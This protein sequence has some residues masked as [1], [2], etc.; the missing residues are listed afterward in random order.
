MF[1]GRREDDDFA[2]RI[3]LHG[4]LMAS[5]RR[6]AEELVKHPLDVFVRM[7]VA[8]PQDHVIARDLVLLLFAGGLGFWNERGRAWAFGGLFVAGVFLSGHVHAL[9]SI[10]KKWA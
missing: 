5:F 2:F 3:D 7:V 10:D 6:V 8:V 9:R 1:L 4:H